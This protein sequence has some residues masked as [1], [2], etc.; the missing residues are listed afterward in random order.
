MSD[1]QGVL[2]YRI[3]NEPT[4][5]NLTALA[6]LAPYMDLACASG[7]VESIRRNVNACGE[8]GWTDAQ[9]VMSLIL[10]NLAGGECVDDLDHLEADAGLGKLVRWCETHGLSRRV[11]RESA[12][13]FRKGRSRSVV[14]ASAARRFLSEFHDEREQ[15]GRVVGKAFIPRPTDSLLGLR[16]VSAGLVGFAQRSSKQ[17]TA[18][19]DMD[20]TLV[21][22]MKSSALYCY[23]HFRA[24]QPFN[25]WWAEQGMMLHSEFR[26]GNVPA[27]YQQTRVLTEAL[28]YLPDGVVKVRIRSDTAGYEHELMRYCEKGASER[29]GRIEFAISAD[30]T[31]EF[32]AA[33]EEV[34]EEDWH[35]LY[36]E[37]DGRMVRTGREWAEVCFVPSPIAFGNNAPVYRYLATREALRD[38][39]LP[40]MDEAQMSLPF[41]TMSRGGLT[42]KVFGVVTNLGWDGAAVIRFHDG[43]CGKCEEAHKI[44]KEDFAGSVMPSNEFGANAAWWAIAV[45]AMNL[46]LVMNRAVLGGVW[47]NK[48][49]KAIR[50]LIMCVPGRVVDKARQLYLRL[51]R[52]HPALELLIEM[53][54]RICELAASP[55]IP[56]SS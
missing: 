24:Y 10:L 28:S 54:R 31:R 37:V 51:S 32:K 52:D 42:Y 22:T 46:A 56:A 55:P 27:G 43:R 48:R 15:E 49:M 38:Q 14:S 53:R 9:V 21:E 16:K 50:F 30:V 33:V 25:I 18:T 41:Q 23:K 8:Q 7:L 2:S 11:R 12:R 26:D 39:P 29:F 20:A 19:L 44:L 6:G 1:K 3:E 40:G 35:P 36:K 4:S 47:T 13:R 45:L 17:M 34:D 5:Q